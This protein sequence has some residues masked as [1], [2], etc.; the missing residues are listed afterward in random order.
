MPNLICL[1]QG[2]NLEKFIVVVVKSQKTKKKKKI[3]YQTF[4]MVLQFF[5]IGVGVFYFFCPLTFLEYPPR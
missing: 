5:E 1:N 2:L 3:K 4:F